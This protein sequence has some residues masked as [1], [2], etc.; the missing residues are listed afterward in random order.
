MAAEA[1]TV[2]AGAAKTA[3]KSGMPP[4]PKA[5]RAPAQQA[6]ASAQQA[7]AQPPSKRAASQSKR[8]VALQ[9]SAAHRHEVEGRYGGAVGEI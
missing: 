5:G 9:Q 7:Q 2:A 1:A 3:L 4:K 8:A 6:Q